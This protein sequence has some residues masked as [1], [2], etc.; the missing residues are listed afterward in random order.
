MNTQWKKRLED[1]GGEARGREAPLPL[2]LPPQPLLLHL[3]AGE[4]EGEGMGVAVGAQQDVGEDPHDMEEG[5]HRQQ[6]E[7][8]PTETLVPVQG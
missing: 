1:P 4:T 8:G 2:L 6:A 3:E 5:G 7:E